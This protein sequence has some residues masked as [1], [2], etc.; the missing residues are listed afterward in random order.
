[1]Q[2]DSIPQTNPKAL[3][4]VL[5]QLSSLA[6]S[7]TGTSCIR[8]WFQTG[9]ILLSLGLEY[10][11]VFIALL[12]SGAALATHQ[13]PVTHILTLSPGKRTAADVQSLVDAGRVGSIKRVFT[14][15]EGASSPPCDSSR[16]HS[17]TRYAGV[18]PYPLD[19]LWAMRSHAMV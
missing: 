2:S 6:R 19:D 11:C 1:M 14:L 13:S 17:V 4:S 15:S 7:T 5:L 10:D 18:F 3:A 9:F 8:L 12:S 16:H